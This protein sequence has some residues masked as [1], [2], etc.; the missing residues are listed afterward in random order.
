[1]TKAKPTLFIVTDVET[2]IPKGAG[3]KGLVF[4]VA[5]K[6]V[7][8]KGRE[9]GHGSYLAKDVISAYTPWF[10]EKVGRYF[11]MAYNRYIEPKTFRGIAKEYNRQ[12][13]KLQDQGYKIIFCAY[14]AG[15]DCG[16]LGFTSQIM[17]KRAFLLKPLP[18]LCI[19][20]YWARSCPTQYRAELTASGKFVKTSAEA[21][22]RYEFT[23]PRFIEAH[24]GWQDVDIEADILLKVLARKKKMPLVRNPKDLP[25]HVYRIANKRLRFN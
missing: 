22:F 12:V 16:A 13:K 7:D 14:N 10:K 5:W 18:I 15:F 2:C 19:W 9:Y 17:N 23:Q 3:N 24:I 8:R 6:I 11:E 25:G 20:E 4:D 21:V 1:M